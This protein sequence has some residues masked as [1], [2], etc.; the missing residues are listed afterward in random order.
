MERIDTLLCGK[1]TLSILIG[2]PTLNPLAVPKHNLDQLTTLYAR[3][4][5]PIL[6][7]YEQDGRGKQRKFFVLCCKRNGIYVYKPT[8]CKK[9]LIRLYFSIYPLHISDR[10]SPSSGA[11]FLKV[12]CRISYMPV[13]TDTS[14]CC[15][16]I[17]T[18]QP[19]VSAY[20]KYDI[21]VTKRL[22]LKMD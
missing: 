18:Q 17:A 15:M 12:V 4:C 9:F 14:D 5:I 3:H 13:Y 1:A 16:A 6:H 7:K 19:D 11:I 21:E 22:L 10:I 20:T 8:R 2:D